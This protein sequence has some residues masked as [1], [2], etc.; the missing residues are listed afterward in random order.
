MP[1]KIQRSYQGN[2]EEIETHMMRKGFSIAT[3]ASK[4]K[5]DRKTVDRIFKG[6]RS[7]IDTYQSIASV[8]DVEDC[9]SLIYC[10]K[11]RYQILWRR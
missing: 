7:K 6:G 11:K 9:S 5:V 4:A 2:L 3:L 10:D 1:K 8:L